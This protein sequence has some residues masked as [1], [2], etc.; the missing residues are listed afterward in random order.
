MNIN[1]IEA[2]I[3]IEAKVSLDMFEDDLY[4]KDEYIAITK[5][6]N[7][8][9]SNNGDLSSKAK[10]HLKYMIQLHILNNFE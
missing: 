10:K 2:L 1:V 7:E 6:L 4:T 8:L 9:K 3:N 5:V